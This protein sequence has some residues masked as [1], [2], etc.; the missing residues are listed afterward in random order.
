VP[1]G[2][3]PLALDGDLSKWDP[4]QFVIIDERTKLQALAALRVAGDR[5]YAAF[6]TG[7]AQALENSGSSFQ[8]LFKTGGALDVMLAT[9][10]D[11]DPRRKSAAPGDIRLL[12]S[13]VRGQPKAVLYRPVASTGSRNSALF[14]SPLRTLKFDDVEDVSQ[15]VRLA[16][17]KDAMPAN[18]ASIGDFEF[19]IPLGVLGLKPTPGTALRGD[20]GLLRG[21]GLRTTQRVY[22]SNKSAGLVSDIPS[23][24][25][26]TPQLWGTLKFVLDPRDQSH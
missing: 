26:L 11:S 9:D 3:T 5:L 19:S 12:V 18:S 17:G 10:P 22:W 4:K 24:A 2:T 14:E 13:L 23:E 6:K 1:V 15:Y 8:N 20:V 21:D 7:E 16:K 25:E